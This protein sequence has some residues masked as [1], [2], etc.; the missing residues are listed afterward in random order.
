MFVRNVGYFM[1]NNVMFFDGE[2]VLEG[3]MDG[4]VILFIVKYDFLGNSKFKNSCEGSIYIVKF[5]MYGLEEVVFFNV[6]FGVIEMII[7]V[8][9]NIFKMGIMDEE[10]CMSINF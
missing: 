1:I 4:L 7:D 5:K 2:E 6:L 9:V 10:C 3:I 8:L